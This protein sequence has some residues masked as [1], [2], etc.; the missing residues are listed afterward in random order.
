MERKTYRGV[1]R[2]RR[3]S[4]S[5]AAKYRKI[6]EQVMD[7]FPPV[8]PSPLKVVI[9]KL[10]AMRE[11]KGVSLPELAARTGLLRSTLARLETRKNA[12]LRTLERYAE[13]LD[14]HLEIDIVSADVKNRRL[15]E[16]VG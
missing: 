15:R 14:C 8:K 6:R 16:A 7:E 1:S 4:K 11:A 9:A 5:E 10:R 2:T 3:L 13:G 12:S